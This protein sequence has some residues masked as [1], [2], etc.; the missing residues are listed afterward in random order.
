MGNLRLFQVKI[1]MRI[2]CLFCCTFKMLKTSH[3]ILCMIHHPSPSINPHHLWAETSR[4]RRLSCLIFPLHLPRR[5]TI[6]KPIILS[7]FSHTPPQ[8]PQPRMFKSSRYTRLFCRSIYL[9]CALAGPDKITIILWALSAFP[10][11]VSSPFRPNSN[12]KL[13]T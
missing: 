1:P 8:T 12:E 11:T 7:A 2:C 9:D 13:E 3:P 6:K 5:L 4:L 10:P